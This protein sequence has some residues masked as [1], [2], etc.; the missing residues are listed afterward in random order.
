MLRAALSVLA[1][2]PPRAS[3][4]PADGVLTFSSSAPLPHVADAGGLAS[5]GRLLSFSKSVFLSVTENATLAVVDALSLKL[6]ASRGVAAPRGGSIS[7][8]LALVAAASADGSL[9]A[10]STAAPFARAWTIRVGFEAG[11]V[12]FDDSTGVAY[13]AVSMCAIDGDGGGIAAVQATKDG[14]TLLACIATGPDMPG[15]FSLSPVSD[16]L[17]VSVP[18][19]TSGGAIRVIDRSVN[20][21]VD[22]WPSSAA[23]AAPDAQRIDASGLRLWV[24]TLGDG[25]AVPAQF[26]VLDAL[27]GTLLWATPAPPDARCSVEV[28][29]FDEL[30]FFACGGPASS[31]WVVQTKTTNAA[32]VPTAWTALGAVSSLPPG[33]VGVHSLSWLKSQRT[34]FL[35]APFV[36]AANQS[37]AIYAFL[38]AGPASG[39]DDDAGGGA[40]AA[41]P[42]TS[43]WVGVLVGG[44]VISLVLGG[45][46]ARRFCPARTS[47]SERSEA[48]EEEFIPP[49]DV[50]SSLN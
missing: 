28:D 16:M 13:V 34:L 15:D 50:E 23:W 21:V 10:W 49:A 2:A 27:D 11:D 1:L 24:T 26:I 36:A 45:C 12:H 8:S 35:A 47:E 37:A 14:A 19:A 25:D 38:G 40:P 44:C 39:D 4:S 20:A 5:V 18:S 7:P 43:I 41:V 22:T 6:V 33:L 31:L 32:G 48:L 46:L 9:S 42:L 30:I 3:S 17:T 29:G